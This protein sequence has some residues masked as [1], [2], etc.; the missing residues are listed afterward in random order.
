VLLTAT[1]VNNSLWDL[2]YQLGYFIKN[3]AAFAHTGIPSLRERFNEAQARDPAELTP[4]IL[5]DVL[6]ETTVRRTRRFIK[7]RY[8]GATMPDDTGEPCGSP[9]PNSSPTGWST[10]SSRP[11][12]M[13]T[14][15]TSRWGSRAT[16][17]ASGR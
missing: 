12:A 16:L 8:A 13:R 17:P 9:S 3:D 2:Y 1:P 6:D 15:R 5:F 7:E 11:S 10:S 4:D 14:S